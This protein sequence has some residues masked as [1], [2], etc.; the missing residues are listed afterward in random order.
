MVE[1]TRMH[2]LFVG[3][4]GSTLET[5]S[6][7]ERSGALASVALTEGVTESPTFLA[8]DE[9]RQVLFAISE[10]AGADKPEP[11][12]ATSF[13][14]DPST[15]ALTKINDVWSGGGNTVSVQLTRSGQA[16]LTASS[17][18]AEGRVAVIP[19]AAD[20]RLSEP[21]D[22]Q[23]AGKNAHGQAQSL[24]GKFVYVVCRGSEHVAQYRF[25]E[26]RG[27]LQAL[28][29]PSVLLP[30]PSGPRRIVVHPALPVAYV[31][32]DWSGEVV[33]YQIADD[34]TLRDPQTL[35]IF[36]AGKEPRAVT[37]TM[38]AAELEV[39][40][41]GRTVYAT[42]RTPDCQSIAVLGVGA[43]GRLTLVANEYGNGLIQ[44]PRH[45]MLSAD[46]H[47]LFVANQDNDTLLVFA[48]DSESRRLSL[49]G[50]A[51]PT[52]V[53]KPNAVAYGSFAT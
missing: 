14:V 2:W 17:S 3:G 48:V 28:A 35:S 38:T 50:S 21:S 51:T 36:P 18:T 9:R 49:R 34:G 45:F 19:V 37:G 40:T 23:I 41:D 6:F 43:Q 32:L 52:R 44:G 25:D 46:N 11:G 20:G 53:K 1:K 27:K 22:S 16:L 39:S 13:R 30:A 10:K 47:H 4:Y 33:S 24:N 26:G 8:L 42:T 15:G 5:F 12:R 29:A 31:I 7:D